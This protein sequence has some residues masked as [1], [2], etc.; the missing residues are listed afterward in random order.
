[1]QEMPWRDAPGRIDLDPAVGTQTERADSADYGAA[2][3]AVRLTRHWQDGVLHA[4]VDNAGPRPV[5]VRQ[6]VLLQWRHGLP[7]TTPIHGEGFQM[8]AQTGG[9]LGR[10]RLLGRCDDADV[11]RIYSRPW[12]PSGCI[13]RQAYN[14]FVYADQA[15]FTLLGFTRCARFSGHIVFDTEQFEVVLDL[16]NHLLQAGERLQLEP[17]TVLVDPSLPALMARYATLL[18]QAH[19]LR[20]QRPPPRGWCSWYHYYATVSADDIR[21]NL[22]ALRAYPNLEYVQIDDGYQARMGDWLLPSDKFADGVDALIDTIHRAGRK[23]GIWLAP[24]IAES[25]SALF[26]THPDWFVRRADGSPLPAEEVTYGGW[27]CTPWYMLDGTH[28]QALAYLREVVTTM[29]RDWKVDYFKLDALYWG[30]VHGGLRQRPNATRI[31]AYRAALQVIHDAADGAFVL[32]C[33]APMWPSLGLVDG[34]RIGDDIERGHARMLQ[35][36]EETF[37]RNWMHRR[38][39]LNDP[40]C[41]VL[42]N[43]PDQQASAADYRLHLATV[44]GSG[45]LLMSGDRLALLDATQCTQLR[46]LLAVSQQG[47]GA[48]SFHSFDCTLGVCEAEGVDTQLLCVTNVDMEARDLR[49]PAEADASLAVVFGAT[50]ERRQDH[51]VVRLPPGDGAVIAVTTGGHNGRSS[52]RK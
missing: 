25:G 31:E 1:M 39:W 30:A 33:N 17:F 36:R 10:P 24:F 29:R 44:L 21:E 27:R 41:L 26:Q 51:W 52:S 37:R 40:D 48:A 7:D 12:A 45:G 20:W 14:C 43:L 19:P 5:H 8:L 13:R 9:E 32:G 34:M 4:T 28:P 47:Y 15:R 3:Q 49:L 23:A 18:Q 6:V 35:V 2:V 46:T 38:L 42:C 50:P 11:Y 16:E 22:D